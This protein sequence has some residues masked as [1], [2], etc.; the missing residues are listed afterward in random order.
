MESCGDE[1]SHIPHTESQ[2][3]RQAEDSPRF[4]NV[5]NNIITDEIKDEEKIEFNFA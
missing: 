4:A 2:S 3:G 5:M 1:L